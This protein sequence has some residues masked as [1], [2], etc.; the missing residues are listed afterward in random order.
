MRWLSSQQKACLRPVMPGTVWPLRSKSQSPAS[1]R[2]FGPPVPNVNVVSA[3][4]GLF[5]LRRK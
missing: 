3:L 4:P 1:G 2:A 5:E